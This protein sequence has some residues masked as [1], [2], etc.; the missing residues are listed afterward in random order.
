MAIN[1][2]QLMQAGSPYYTSA[3]QSNLAAAD[4]I[5]TFLKNEMQRKREKEAAA[6]QKGG[7][8]GKI[9]GAAGAGGGALLGGLLAAPTGGLSPLAGALIGGGVGGMGGSLAGS[10]FDE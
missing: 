9:G 3:V 6:R 8:F 1:P 10:I 2:I 4:V 7:L 5:G